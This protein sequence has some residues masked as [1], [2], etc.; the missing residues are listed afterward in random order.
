MRTTVDIDEDVL[1][2]A[3]SLAQVQRRSIGSVLSVLARRGLRSSAPTGLGE[4]G[5]PVFTLT[6]GGRPITSE[7]V[8][9][10]QDDDT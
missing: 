10:A 1:S 8:R 2:A 9:A 5:F 3:R 4:G 6:S 7:M